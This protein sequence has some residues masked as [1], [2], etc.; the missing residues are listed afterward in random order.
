MCHLEWTGLCQDGENLYHHGFKGLLCS[1]GC[2]FFFF[3]WSS[4]YSKPEAKTLKKNIYLVKS[5]FSSPTPCLCRLYKWTQDLFEWGYSEKSHSPSFIFS[6]YSDSIISQCVYLIVS[7][8]NEC[9]DFLRLP[10]NFRER[11]ILFMLSWGSLPQMAH[12]CLGMPSGWPI[13]RHSS[14]SEGHLVYTL[15]FSPSLF[16]VLLSLQAG[17]HHLHFLWCH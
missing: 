17:L 6:L 8:L 5:S 11:Q 12:L 14:G 4:F 2:F 16:R 10:C 1:L 9:S 7:L 13:G 15:P 3:F